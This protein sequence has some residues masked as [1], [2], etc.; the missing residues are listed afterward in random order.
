MTVDSLFLS[1]RNF[2]TFLQLE[3]SGS[4][5]WMPHLAMFFWTFWVYVR[6]TG[7]GVPVG[8]W[9]CVSWLLGFANLGVR[10]PEMPKAGVI[11]A[12]R[13]ADVT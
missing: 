6:E 1:L 12:F 13:I 7:A 11:R 5:L 3:V 4:H 8:S 10:N 9:E 2:V